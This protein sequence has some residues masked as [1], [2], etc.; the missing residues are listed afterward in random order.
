ML[1]FSQRSIYITTKAKSEIHEEFNR[2]DILLN[3]KEITVKALEE[4]LS[5]YDKSNNLGNLQQQKI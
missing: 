1:T 5:N 4:T 2:R 3:T